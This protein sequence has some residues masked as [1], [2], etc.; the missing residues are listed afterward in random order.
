MNKPIVETPV[1]EVQY[2][3]ELG[4]FWWK[5]CEVDGC[6]NQICLSKDEVK[7]C[8]P[9]SRWYRKYIAAIRV[10]FGRFDIVRHEQEKESEDA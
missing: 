1:V 4:Y 6:T 3:D 7:Y 2:Q 5:Q 10:F 9:H 8:Y